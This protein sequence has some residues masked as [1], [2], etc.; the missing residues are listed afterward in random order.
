MEYARIVFEIHVRTGACRWERDAS[1][2]RVLNLAA[3]D[4]PTNNQLPDA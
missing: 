2:G 4:S 3:P 1:R